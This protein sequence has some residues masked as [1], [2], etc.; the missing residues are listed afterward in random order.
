MIGIA[1]S[2]EALLSLADFVKKR[3]DEITRL[4]ADLAEAM[5]AL[6]NA[7]LILV[8]Y[9]PDAED[10]T[11]HDALIE[12]DAITDKYKDSTHGK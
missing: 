12:I 10:R 3:E 2:D 5:E 9:A 7:R 11:I 8:D 6:K 1:P 4:R